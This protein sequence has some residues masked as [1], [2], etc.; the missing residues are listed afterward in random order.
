VLAKVDGSNYNVTWITPASGGG[1]SVAWVDITGKPSTF[2]PSIHTHAIADVTGLQVALDGK[3]ASGSYAA[4]VHTHVIA[5]ITGLQTTIDQRGIPVGG[6]AGQVLSKVDGSNYNVTWTA[7]TGGSVAWADITGKPSTF[8]PSAH[9]HVIADVTG[10]QSS[11][12]GKAASSH[13]H[14]IADITGLQ[15][16]IDQRGIPAGGTTGQVLAKVD[17]SN[18]NVTWITP[19]SGGGGSV[20][21]ADITGKPSTF[22]PSIHTHVIA[23]VTNLQ[24]SLDGKAA[25]SHTHVIAD[26]TGLQTALNTQGMPTGGAA[27]QVLT[28]ISAIDYNAGW[29]TPSGG[30]GGGGGISQTVVTN[31]TTSQEVTITGLDLSSNKWVVSVV[32]EW[33]NVQADPFFANVG[34]LI[35]ANGTDGATSIPN[36]IPGGTNL[37]GSGCTIS[38]AKAKYGGSSLQLTAGV[39]LS[40]PTN[41]NTT[42]GTGNFTMEFWMYATNLASDQR[43]I[44][45]GGANQWSFGTR[46][47]GNRTI[48]F[49]QEGVAWNNEVA[50][51]PLFNQWVHIAVC[52]S[53]TTV[54]YFQNGILIGT[55]TQGA[56]FN[57]A[58]PAIVSGNSSTVWYDD[59]RITKAARYTANFT[60]PEEL[61][62]TGILV[63]YKY[64]GSIGGL[65]DTGVDYGVQKLSNTSLKVKKMSATTPDGTIPIPATVDRV[66]INVIEYGAAPIPAGG[67]AGQVLAKVNSTDYN[68]TWQTLSGGGG[69]VAWVD[70]TGKPSQFPPDTHTHGISDVTGLQT[71]LDGKAATGHGHSIADVSGLQTALDGKAASVHGHAIGDVT[72]LQTA[73]DAK[74]SSV[75][76]HAIADVT[77]LQTVLDAASGTP[78]NQAT[79]KLVRKASAGIIIKGQVV[80]IVGSQGTHLTVELADADAEATAATTIGVAMGNITSSVDGYIIVQG[81][82]DGLNNLPTAAFTDG[83]ALWLSPTAGA[84]T[85]TRPTQPA[86]GV[87][88]GW[89]VSASNGASGRAYIKIINGQELDELHDVLITS[90]SE[91]QV[92]TYESA[93]GLWKNKPAS[94]GGGGITNGQSIVN[95]LIFG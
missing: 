33:D 20:A 52:R 13:T 9:S 2:P 45:G 36:E 91:G 77:G 87:F 37:T 58:S 42:F 43:F 5:D 93:S 82:L 90:P 41:A 26:I 63:S 67:T 46:V 16:T 14:V 48:G 40:Y 1:G 39:G 72:G 49:V 54:R 59:I 88:I 55:G 78:L 24:T 15:S 84:W 53:G 60:P 68:Y 47:V 62:T 83:Q 51:T 75:H 3:Q 19:A 31:M 70:I 22:P 64:V 76:T 92:L 21:W 56:S 71:A 10:L 81:Y 35:R 69:P 32:E 17:G 65:N 12:D 29:V 8:P 28:K 74:A 66:F 86:H 95:A 94:G 50:W 61:N 80:Y 38:T 11:L 73:L 27:G 18:Y 34:L 7:P 89:V 30:G 44:N 79:I 23:D 57:M 6:T 85:N 25:A 4:A